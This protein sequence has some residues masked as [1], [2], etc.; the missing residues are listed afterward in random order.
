MINHAL[1]FVDTMTAE[2]AS[3]AVSQPPLWLWVAQATGAIATTIGVLI[4]LYIA[5]VREPRNAAEDRRHHRAQLD[6]LRRAEMAR[7]AAHARKVVSSCVKTPMFGDSCWAVRIDNASS[8]MTT[9][10][11]V[12]VKAIDANGV[13]V[14][15][16]CRQANNTRSVDEAFERSIIAALSL[17]LGDGREPLLASRGIPPDAARHTGNQLVHEFKQAIRDAMVSHVVEGWPRTLPAN[18]H[19]LMAYTTTDANYRLSI[20]IDYEDEAGYRWRRTD[21]GEP[22]RTDEETPIGAA[23]PDSRGYGHGVRARFDLRYLL[24]KCV[25]ARRAI[26]AEPS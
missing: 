25:G 13:E 26:M 3:H 11:S 18:H 6:A 5:V 4:A 16:G 2:N 19:M 23:A 7:I 15:D 12:D 17:P 14:S 20:A 22:R 8:A 9:I 21:T 10:L 24:P 1:V